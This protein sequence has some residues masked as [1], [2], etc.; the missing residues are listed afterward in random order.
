MDY[1]QTLDYLYNRLPMFH[2]IGKAAYKADLNNTIALCDFLGNPHLNFRSIH[3]AGTNGKGST[4]HLL[5][6]IL[7]AAGY[8]TGLY[9]SPHLKSFTERIRIDG[10]EIEPTAV[11]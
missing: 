1:A 4:S 9:T 11:V 3:V 8:R 7:Q 5:A 10:R 2:R 6:A